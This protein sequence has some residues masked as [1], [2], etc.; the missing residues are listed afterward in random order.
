MQ[1]TVLN[2]IAAIPFLGP[3]VRNVLSIL[4]L[5]FTLILDAEV[6]QGSNAGAAKKEA[7]RV[8]V[9]AEIAK[10]GGLEWPSVINPTFQAKIVDTC[11]ELLVF[12]ANKFGFFSKSPTT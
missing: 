10:P 6:R 9:L 7:V 1:E 8:Q 5:T 4:M 12:L 11:I 3:L 2:L